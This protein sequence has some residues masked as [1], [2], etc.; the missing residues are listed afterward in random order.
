MVW[1]DATICTAIQRGESDRSGRPQSVAKAACA[2]AGYASLWVFDNSEHV[3]VKSSAW[4]GRREVARAGA[5]KRAS[6]DRLIS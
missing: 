5:R 3:L 2:G 1:T 6:P 4:G